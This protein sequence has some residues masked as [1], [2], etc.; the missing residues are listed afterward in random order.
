MPDS[1]IYTP[2]EGLVNALAATHA[3]A[4]IEPTVRVPKP[5]FGPA[6]DVFEDGTPVRPFEWGMTL[7]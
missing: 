5:N 6:P 2:T 7:R 3:A 1:E 4:K